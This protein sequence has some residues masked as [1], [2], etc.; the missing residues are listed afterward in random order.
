M[1]PTEETADDDLPPLSDEVADAWAA[2]LIDVHEKRK[3]DVT[4]K[5]SVTEKESFSSEGE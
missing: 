5:A 1:D 2:V 3:N 4:T